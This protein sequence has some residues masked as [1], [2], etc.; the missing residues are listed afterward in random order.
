MVNR[1][2]VRKLLQMLDV[3]TLRRLAESVLV[4]GEMPTRT[5]SNGTL[6]VNNLIAD[7]EAGNVDTNV[8]VL[9][10]VFHNGFCYPS[11]NCASP[12]SIRPKI[13]ID[14]YS[15]ERV[16]YNLVT[17]IIFHQSMTSPM[18]FRDH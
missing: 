5:C 8:C 14:V 9:I 12:F 7:T 6:D 2:A 16:H 15:L 10:Q 1:E 17:R 11:T 18:S 3:D 4:I 13:H